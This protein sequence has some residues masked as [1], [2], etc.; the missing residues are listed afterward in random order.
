VSL[1]EFIVHDVTGQDLRDAC[2]QG[3]GSAGGLDGWCARDLALLSDHA[4]DLLAMMCN[5]LEQGARW[6]QATRKVRA[7]FLNKD[8]E[9]I[10]NPLAYRVLKVSS[11]VYRKWGSMRL[12]HLE[13]WQR[14]WDHEFVNAGVPDK[15]AQN[16]WY[17]EAVFLELAKLENVPTSGGGVDIYKCFD[18][19]V[20]ELIYALAE[21]AGMPTR[22][23]TAYRNY[24]EDMEVHFQTGGTI[25][26]AHKDRCSIP[27]GCPFSMCMLALTTTTWIHFIVS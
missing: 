27:Q 23:L 25:G 5:R 10:A 21:R 8:P 26:S 19:V 18:Q 2:S 16:A 15:S 9:D 14:Q 13:E 1:P 7:V 22:I 6:P 4:F 17:L 11:G 12:R 24:L 20:R 3:L